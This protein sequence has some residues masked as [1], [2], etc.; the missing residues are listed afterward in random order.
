MIKV[1]VCD[2]IKF[3]REELKKRLLEYSFKKNIDFDVD[4]YECGEDIILSDKSYDLIFMDYE[5]GEGKKNGIEVVRE[6]R[7]KDK[8]VHIIFLTSYSAMVYD[9]F[10]VEAFRF[11]V[12][13]VDN[14][15]LKKAL[16]DYISQTVADEYFQIKVDG[17]NRI[18]RMSNIIYIEG[19]G[20]KSIIHLINSNEVIECRL[21]L[22][23]L[24][25]FLNAKL[26]F[27]C[28]KSY[29]VNLNYIDSYD[30]NQII[31]RNKDIVMISRTKYSVFKDNY[32][33]FL[34]E[35]M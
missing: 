2:D 3:M 22:L 29:I 25:K 35:N 4:E 14:E 8:S 1:G 13:P 31:V 7:K 30:K 15:K 24:E 34:F 5:L 19:M 27:R 33:K 26:F 20:K 16:D 10:E 23:E 9:V 17:Q 12:K 6:L 32:A 18:V 21:S 11:L 28:H